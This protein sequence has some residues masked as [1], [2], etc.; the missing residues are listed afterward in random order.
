MEL[1]EVDTPDPGLTFL[2]VVDMADTKASVSFADNL[3]VGLE[4]RVAS[5]ACMFIT[6][7]L[8]SYRY[9]MYQLMY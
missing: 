1:T 7:L 6:T 5:V 4:D 9:K 2:A 3:A 8:S